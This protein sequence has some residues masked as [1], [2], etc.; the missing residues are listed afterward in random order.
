MLT[1]GL[2]GA[3]DISGLHLHNAAP[4][5][6]GP[7]VFGIFGPNMDA[8]DRTVTI[9]INGTVRFVCVW[10]VG[11]TPGLSSGDVDAGREARFSSHR[12]RAQLK[13]RHGCNK[14]SLCPHLH[15]RSVVLINLAV[16]IRGSRH[17]SETAFLGN[18][19]GTCHRCRVAENCY[20][21]FEPGP[22]RVSERDVSPYEIT[23]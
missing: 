5:V 15:R 12:C 22:D 13:S 8:D 10:D 7:V 23:R 1:L 3:N 2:A 14:S 16:G 20:T 17:G 21:H 4:G 6:N 19:L 11:D 18:K 9:D